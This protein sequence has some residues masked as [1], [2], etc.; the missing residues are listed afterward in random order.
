MTMAP[1]PSQHPGVRWFLYGKLS[2][3]P[4]DAP[5]D[6]PNPRTTPASAEGRGR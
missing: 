1:R 3:N 4:D 6:P 2:Q 5:R